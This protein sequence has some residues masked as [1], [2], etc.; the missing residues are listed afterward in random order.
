VITERAVAFVADHKPEA[1]AL[2]RKLA[3][4]LDDPDRFAA[5]LSEGFAKLADPVYQKGSHQVVPTLGASHGVR[6]PLIQAVVRGFREE[7]RRERTSRWLFIADRLF[8]ESEIEAR[9]FAFGLLDRVVIDD[10]ERSWQL[11]RRAAREAGDWATVD[12]LAHPVGKGILHEPYRWA[13]LEQLVFSPSVWERR[14]VGSTVAT[15]P[16]VDRKLGRAP[17]VASHGLGLIGQLIGDSEPDVQKA[18]A[19][20][21]RSLVIV[22]PAAVEAF[23]VDEAASARRTADGHRAW[24]IRDTLPKL[25]EGVAAT[26][27]QQLDGIRRRPGA[28]SSSKASRTADQF[29][30]MGLGGPLPEPP[31]T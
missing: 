9:W 28:P 24:V 22:D 19:W 18:L 27:R 14:L 7:T 2:G 5:I 12:A 26:L 16:F 20:A 21:L 4:E 6:W 25:D 15:I 31:L 3:D 23:C 30:E 29:M 17:D 13:E 1:E 11:L 10:P 8:R